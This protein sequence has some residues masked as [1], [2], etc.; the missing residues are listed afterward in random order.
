M[1]VVGNKRKWATSPQSRPLSL[2]ELSMHHVQVV[3]M[4]I[5]IFSKGFRKKMGDSSE[6]EPPMR[7]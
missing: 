5:G 6:E 2:G 1:V 3:K 4:I 7:E